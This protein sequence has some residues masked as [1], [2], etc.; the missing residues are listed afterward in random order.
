MS[1]LVTGGAGFIGT[2]LCRGLIA[3]NNRVY[4]LDNLS[5]SPLKNIED[6]LKH[7]I[8]AF[9]GQDEWSLLISRWS[10]SSILH[11]WPARWITRRI[12]FIRE[13]Q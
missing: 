5:L 4:G 3:E 1:V 6:L 13:N 9:V 7:L 10:G 12:R 8:L 2:H 11:V